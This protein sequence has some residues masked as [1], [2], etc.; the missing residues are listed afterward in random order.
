MQIVPYE[1]YFN[2]EEIPFHTRSPEKINI[3]I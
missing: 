1:A 3:L 2:N